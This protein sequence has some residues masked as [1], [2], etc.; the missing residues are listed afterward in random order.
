MIA[1][2]AKVLA[3]DPGDAEAASAIAELYEQIDRPRLQ[4]LAADETVPKEVRKRIYV[5]LASK[6]NTCA[7]DITETSRTE[8]NIRGQRSYRY[9]MP[10]NKADLQKGLTCAREGLDLIE[11]A[12]ALAPNDESAWS[13]KTSLLI[14]TA[15]FA[16]MEQHADEKIAYA[17][18]SDQAKSVFRKLSD[19]ARER[20]RKADDDELLR[21]KGRRK[22]RRRNIRNFKNSQQR[23]S[24]FV[25]PKSMAVKWNLRCTDL[26]HLRLTAKE[27]RKKSRSTRKSCSGKL[28]Q[29]THGEFTALLP[30]PLD[31]DGSATYSVDS[32]GVT[33]LISSTK[34]PPAAL[35]STDA[36]LVGAVFEITG[37]VCNFSLMA[38]STCEVSL[39][40]RLN[41]NNYPGVQ[42]NVEETRCENV[43]KGLVRVYAT[44]ERVYTIVIAGADENDPRASKFL[45]SMALK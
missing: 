11:K 29:Q 25:N 30:S 7:N 1:A 41:L 38:K 40:R 9:H 39:A 32:E 26:W 16:E 27:V 13:Y 18:Q 24:G 20:Q 21:N 35:V 31:I 28:F 42:Y 3:S 22:L 10:P 36:M 19:E 23:E 6:S 17:K 34:I 4:D 45:T 8:V 44:R 14:Q 2:Y 5:R 15:R 33:Y 37:A 12:I 43:F